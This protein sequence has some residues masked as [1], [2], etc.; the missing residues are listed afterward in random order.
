MGNSV[1]LTLACS[2]LC[3][4]EDTCSIYKCATK[5]LH[6]EMSE[7]TVLEIADIPAKH[8]AVFG[9]DKC[10]DTRHRYFVHGRAAAKGGH[11]LAGAQI[12]Y[13]ESA[14]FDWRKREWSRRVAASDS[15]K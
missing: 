9:A 14:V 1:R 5:Q 10:R 2:L 3:E 15:G 6:C 11:L 8:G 12:V 7:S 13:M 4:H